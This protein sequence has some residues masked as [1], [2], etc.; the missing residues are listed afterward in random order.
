MGGG[1][2]L[3]MP[4][5]P[6]RVD[7]P[8]VTEPGLAALQV[9]LP[10]PF[11][12]SW[13]AEWLAWGALEQFSAL[14]GW[15]AAITVG[16]PAAPT[17]AEFTALVRM[18][19]DER[20]DALNEIV[21]QAD[22]FLRDFVQLLAATPTSRPATYRLLHIASLIAL[23]AAQYVKRLH[24]RPRPAQL[25]PGLRPPVPLPGHAA[26]PSGHAAQAQL[27]ALCVQAALPAAIGAQLGPALLALA[28]RVA[29]NREI[30]GLHWPTDT[31]AGV[32]LAGDM[33]GV[34][35]NPANAAALPLFVN[36]SAA[37]AGEW[38]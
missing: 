7:L 36:T 28:A 22:D 11:G 14:P 4:L 33:F 10:F 6:D 34:L 35:T 8:F 31:A 19:E 23:F 29:R 1:A 37:V 2:G 27:M 30:A 18:A 21:A 3:G 5:F 12:R 15:R 32:Q 24:N 38:P 13:T 9:P 20:A 26:Y 25:S 17:A 16:A